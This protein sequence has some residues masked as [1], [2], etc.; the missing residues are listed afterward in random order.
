[1]EPEQELMGWDSVALGGEEQE[2]IILGQ[3]QEAR[4]EEGGMG[5]VLEQEGHALATAGTTLKLR[6]RESRYIL[7]NF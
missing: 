2:V 3:Q 5:G 6:T 1:M 7:D 4:G